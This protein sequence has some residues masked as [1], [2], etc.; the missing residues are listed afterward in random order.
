M[1]LSIVILMFMLAA[2]LAGSFLLRRDIPGNL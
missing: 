1:E 2:S